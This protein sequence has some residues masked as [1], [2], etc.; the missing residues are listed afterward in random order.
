MGADAWRR[1]VGPRSTAAR[2]LGCRSRVQL[3]ARRRLRARR[4]GHHEQADRCPGGCVEW[5]DRPLRR[6]ARAA[7]AHTAAVARRAGEPAR[8]GRLRVSP[9][10][11]RSSS[12]HVV[13]HGNHVPTG[14]FAAGSGDRRA[15]GRRVRRAAA[16]RRAGE[17][18]SGG[19]LERAT[20]RR[21]SGGPAA[22]QRTRRY[23]V[24]HRCPPGPRDGRPHLA[25]ARRRH[26]RAG[27]RSVAAVR[28][29]ARRAGD[30]HRSLGRRRHTARRAVRPSPAALL[31]GVRPSCRAGVRPLVRVQPG[32]RRRHRQG[33]GDDPR[34]RRPAAR[35]RPPPRLGAGRHRTR[36]VAHRVDRRRVPRRHRRSPVCRRRLQ[37]E[38][39]AS[40]RR[41]RSAGGVPPRRP[42]RGDDPQ[43][44]PAAGNAL[45]RR[46]PPLS[47]LAARIWVRPRS[48][49]RWHRLS[50]R[51]R[52]D[53]H[54]TPTVDDRPF[55]VFSWRPPAR[56]VLELDALFR[57]GS[58]R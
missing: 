24:R 41:R 25:D 4:H 46:P 6:P 52:H 13:V 23:D 35:V 2:S 30:D 11:G 22:G 10:T 18:G 49:A 16:E 36:R 57:G 56:T 54:R 47:E 31:R 45:L 8:R 15:R 53:R 32:R 58:R 12:A 38:P 5:H 55:G 37:V 29:D 48:P 40:A 27:R 33:A 7:R 17:P 42:R 14:Q 26:R 20:R 9:S 50:V 21:T 34:P 28:S 44:L 3:A 51:A 19:R 43:P 39:P 1:D